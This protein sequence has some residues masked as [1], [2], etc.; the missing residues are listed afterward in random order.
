MQLVTTWIFFSE[1]R[2]GNMSWHACVFSLHLI[3]VEIVS[4]RDIWIW[5]Y[6]IFH[7]IIS[8]VFQCQKDCIC[9]IQLVAAG[10]MRSSTIWQ[11]Y[12]WK[13][14]IYFLL[15]FWTFKYF[16]GEETVLTFRI[17]PDSWTRLNRG[18]LKLEL[19]LKN[20]KQNKFKTG[21]LH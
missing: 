7:I 21:K 5:L 4:F 13:Y 16:H 17:L 19:T 1:L 15:N 20:P 2:S 8:T 18:Y 3:L 9:T 10:L 11:T 12:Q 6:D 14:Y